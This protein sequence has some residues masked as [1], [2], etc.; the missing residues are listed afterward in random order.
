VGRWLIIPENPAV[1]VIQ[2]GVTF[3]KHETPDRLFGLGFLGYWHFNMAFAHWRGDPADDPGW[4]T[5]RE[6][7]CCGEE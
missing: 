2:H 1:P 7:G 6:F 4:A 3:T 5:C